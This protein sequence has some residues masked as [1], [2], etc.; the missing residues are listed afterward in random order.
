MRAGAAADG[1]P[2]GKSDGK[3]NAVT[4]EAGGGLQVSVTAKHVTD[5]YSEDEL[6]RMRQGQ[7]RPPLLQHQSTSTVRPSAFELQR[8]NT[9]YAPPY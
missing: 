3:L 1:K 5:K 9:S 2:D 4:F 8:Q 7:Q 6:L